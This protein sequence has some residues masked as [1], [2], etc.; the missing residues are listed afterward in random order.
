MIF[1]TKAKVPVRRRGGFGREVV[2]NKS[3]T[4]ESIRSIGQCSLSVIGQLDFL[5]SPKTYT[6]DKDTASG[7]IEPTSEPNE[8]H[9]HRSLFTNNFHL[10]LVYICDYYYCYYSGC[11]RC[12]AASAATKQ[13]HPQT[14]HHTA[15]IQTNRVVVVGSL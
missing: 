12:G 5:V 1:S 4:K 9:H 8:P 3:R 6:A 11:C 14:P 10:Y 15:S 7:R 13:H 2:Y